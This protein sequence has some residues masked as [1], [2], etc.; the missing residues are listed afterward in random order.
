MNII[1]H[2][3]K[4]LLKNLIKNNI[5]IFSDKL[6]D[7]LTDNLF[8][9]SSDKYINLIANIQK[10]IKDIICTSLIEII[11]SL[12]LEYKN[13]LTR[14]K[15]YDINKSNVKRTVITIFG[16][17]TFKR[18]YYTNK[19]MG[20]HIFVIDE[21]LDLPKYDHYDP[22][23]KALSID[24]AFLTNQKK[25]GEL[26]GEEISNIFDLNKNRSLLHIPRQSIHNWINKWNIPNIKYERR[27]TPKILYIMADEKYIGCQDLDKDIM[28][29]ACVIFEDIKKI[30]KNRNKL[31]NRFTI[32]MTGP[33]PWEYFLNLLNDIYDLDKVEKIYLLGDGGSWIKSGIEELKVNDNINVDFLLCKF[34]FK[35]SINHITINQEDRKKLIDIVLNNNNKNEFIDKINEI[36]NENKNRKETIDKNKN[37][38]LNHWKNIRLMNESKV[39]SSMES[40]ISHL[41][42]NQFGSRPKG[43]NSTYINKYLKIN[44]FLN[45]GGNIFSFYL[46][47]YENTDSKIYKLNCD[48]LN[49]S[50]YSRNNI[51]IL[52]S[53]LLTPTR[54]KLKSI[55]S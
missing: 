55:V 18:T 23:V 19:L 44:D 41:I 43:Y 31:V 6:V 25:A 8:D 2:N 52:E 3:Y 17:I 46:A 45:N 20:T 50:E 38:I 9:I 15:L 30:S 11:E 28:C 33:D 4:E 42:S 34:H 1:T 54:T 21:F 35:Q 26:V 47:N 13:S 27:E 22:I 10:G 53:G 39:G 7:E 14:K 36:S 40:H 29:K 32:S 12:D 48:C 16:E 51:P 49:L 24:R 5:S 37:Y